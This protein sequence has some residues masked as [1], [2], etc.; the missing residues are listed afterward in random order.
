MSLPRG[1]TWQCQRPT[2]SPRATTVFLAPSDPCDGGAEVRAGDMVANADV[3][4]A[5]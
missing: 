2:S 5:R 1:S 3:R 4:V